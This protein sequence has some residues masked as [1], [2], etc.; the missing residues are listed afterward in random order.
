MTSNILFLAAP[1]RRLMPW[2]SKQLPVVNGW[3]SARR[4]THAVAV[5]LLLAPAALRVDS[6]NTDLGG[7]LGHR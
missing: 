6:I 5:A 1:T 2:L 7:H 4:A 3:F